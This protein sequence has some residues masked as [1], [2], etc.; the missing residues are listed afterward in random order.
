MQFCDA[1]EIGKPRRTKEG[2]LAVRAR[3]ARAGVYDYLGREID[4]EGGHFKADQ[5]VKAYRP[6]DEVFARDAVHSFLMKPITNGHPSVPV[7]ADNWKDHA[8]GV[9]AGALR[10][11]DHLAFDLIIMDAATIADVDSGK[12]ALSNGYG[13]DIEIG[14]GTAPDGT[15]F[16]A[17]QRSI[18]GNHVA[19]VDKARGGPDCRISDG[20]NDLFQICDAAPVILNALDAPEEKPVTK[21]TLD[22]LQIDLSDADAVKAAITKLQGQVADE[23][24]ARETAETKSVADAATIVA[25]DAEITDLKAKL[26]AAAITPAKLADAAKEYAD[27]QAKAKALGVTVAADADTAAIKK[28][29]VDAKMGDAAKGYSAD[30]IDIA[31]TALT[32]DAK[33][34]PAVQSIGAPANSNGRQQLDDA[35][36]DWLGRKETAHRAQSA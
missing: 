3:A 16:N 23:R 32:K 22:G 7:T 19:V 5:V 35:R 9:N 33:P 26:A 15:A 28:A 29:V 20:G 25:K 8:K 10:D 36:A 2:Y 12:R 6:E 4:P 34:A 17:T 13:C 18:R 27:V 31:F 11:G 14:D 21:I 30:H 1:L 24:K